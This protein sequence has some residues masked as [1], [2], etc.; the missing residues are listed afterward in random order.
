MDS[1]IYKWGKVNWRKIPS[2]HGINPNPQALNPNPQ[3]LNPKAPTL[4]TLKQHG[5][6]SP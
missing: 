1:G 3:A 4:Q 5:G 6:P 2:L